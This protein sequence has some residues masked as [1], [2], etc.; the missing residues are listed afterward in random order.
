M[1]VCRMCMRV[2]KCGI[3]IVFQSNYIW[4]KWKIRQDLSLA[5]CSSSLGCHY[6]NV[7]SILTALFLACL[8]T[9]PTF[10][11]I[12]T[13]KDTGST[14]PFELCMLTFKPTDC[15]TL[16]QSDGIIFFLLSILTLFSMHIQTLTSFVCLAQIFIGLCFIFFSIFLHKYLDICFARFT[17]DEAM[18][19]SS[20]SHYRNAHRDPKFLAKFRIKCLGRMD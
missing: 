8:H 15:G 9:S 14:P 5:L 3:E 16:F 10:S 1:L 4:R 18:F 12:R 19:F 17:F 13:K 20:S 6:I 7:L 2:A 11:Q